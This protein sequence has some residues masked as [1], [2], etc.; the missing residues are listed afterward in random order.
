LIARSIASGGD[1]GRVEATGARSFLNLDDVLVTDEG[2]PVHAQKRHK[3]A[4]AER[5]MRAAEIQSVS[6]RSVSQASR[7]FQEQMGHRYRSSG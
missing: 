1:I 4:A 3:L 6:R 7:R 5:P 2:E